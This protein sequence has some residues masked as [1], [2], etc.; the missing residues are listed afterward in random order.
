MSFRRWSGQEKDEG[1]RAAQGG[2]RRKRNS[3]FGV[4]E[5]SPCANPADC[6]TLVVMEPL[7]SVILRAFVLSAARCATFQFFIVA[8]NDERFVLSAQSTVS[9]WSPSAAKRAIHGSGQTSGNFKRPATALDLL[10]CE[11]LPTRSRTHLFPAK[12]A[13]S[14]RTAIQDA[15]PPRRAPKTYVCIV[16]GARRR[17]G[18]LRAGMPVS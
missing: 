1:G 18:V 8:R 16:C 6:C 11:P 17:V 9:P 4:V 10:R 3:P 7:L 5:S 2:Q 12:L 14:A 13:H 15:M